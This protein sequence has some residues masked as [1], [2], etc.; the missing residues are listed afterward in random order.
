[1][2][3]TPQSPPIL[4]LVPPTQ[5]THANL[6][7]SWHST[8]CEA[9]TP[10]LHLT[11][12]IRFNP[13]NTWSAVY[14]YYNNRT[15]STT[16]FTLAVEGRYLNGEHLQYFDSH[17]NHLYLDFD[18]G[19]TNGLV[20]QSGS[21][22]LSALIGCWLAHLLNLI[23][24]MF[25]NLNIFLQVAYPPPPQVCRTTSTTCTWLYPRPC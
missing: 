19:N 7:G 8:V 18:H 16:I 14:T 13:G 20:Y 5:P 23:I 3:S 24:N 15:C 6:A 11:R 10:T 17:F 2:S 4:H 21:I 12:L 25:I 22:C 9:R 1:M